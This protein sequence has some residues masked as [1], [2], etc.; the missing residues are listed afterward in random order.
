MLN[1]LQIISTLREFGFASINL[2]T[3]EIEQLLKALRQRGRVTKSELIVKT[4]AEARPRSLSGRFGVGEF[5]H[6][7]DFAFRPIPP[8]L[9]VLHNESSH[10]FQ[11]A[12][13]VSAVDLL[14]ARLLRTLDRSSWHLTNGGRTFNVSAR[15][16]IGDQSAIR[17]DPL[18]LS[19]AN[20]AAHEC[21][22]LIPHQLSQSQVRHRWSPGSILIIDNWRSTHAREALEG[23]GD[24]DRRIIR[25]EVW[26]HARMDI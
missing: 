7:T 24:H 12:T 3:D 26:Q 22:E 13:F 21:C 15:I 8:R 18:C 5:P 19:A 25:Y 1:I 10:A 23:G 4:P 17:W 6:H 20:A 9:L 16:P 2:A 14:P 11:R